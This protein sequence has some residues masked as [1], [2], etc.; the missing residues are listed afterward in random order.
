MKA[1]LE[2]NLPEENEEFND[3]LEGR[4]WKSFAISFA[5]YL[6]QQ[7][8]YCEEEYTDDQ[9]KTLEKIREQFYELLNEDNLS[10]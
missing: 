3:S 1:T 2:F 7:V 10:L 4:K 8:K 5:E 6:R 9:Y